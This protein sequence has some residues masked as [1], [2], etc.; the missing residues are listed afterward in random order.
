MKPDLIYFLILAFIILQFIF[1]EVIDYL[2][3][4][5]LDE[6]LPDEFKGV[7]D[8]EKYKK[9]QDYLKVNTR[10]SGINSLVSISITVAFLALKGPGWLD[11]IV[12][13]WADLWVWRSLS[14]VGVLY[15]F[16][17]LTSIPFSAYGTFVIEE[18][19]GF[20]KTTVKTFIMDFLKSLGLT[21]VIGVPV[22]LALI[23][24]FRTYSTNGWLLAWCALTLFSLVMMYVAPVWIMPLFNKFTPLD[25][26]S[27]LNV[28]IKAMC[29]KADF[30]LKGIYTMDGSKRSAKS[31]AFFTGFGKNKK[32]ALFDTLIEKHTTEE[33][34]AVLA[35]EI[36]H[37]KKKHIFQSMALSFMTSALMLFLLGLFLKSRV[38]FTAFGIENPS[39]YTGLLLFGL[40]YAPISFVIGIFQSILSR[41][42]EFEADRFAAEITGTPGVMIDALKKL[43]ADNLSN[44]TP[45][46]LKVFLEYSHPPV[47]QRIEALRE[48]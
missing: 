42:N 48:K 39:V 30:T 24:F 28:A 8:R 46:P 20:N 17:T 36:G 9:S 34:V 41:K 5:A 38:V 22:Y 6:H 11:G 45:H 1:S 47:L 32:I 4:K 37:Y 3:I 27:E 10:F 18:R 31:N 35:H 26:G 33:L 23:W 29:K 40:V 16:S 7:F 13:S 2:N 19:F 21:I 44:L 15:A 43:S 12:S 25:E 14:F